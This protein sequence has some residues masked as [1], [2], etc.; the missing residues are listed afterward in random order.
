M[1]GGTPVLLWLKPA[2]FAKLVGEIDQSFART[3][4]GR[5]I[6]I[7]RGVFATG[8]FYASRERFYFPYVC[9]MWVA[10]KL[11]H[12]G[13]PFFLPRAILSNSL[14]LQAREKGVMLQRHSGRPEDY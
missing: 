10:V 14:I 8:R 5:R 6:Y 2:S 7:G 12:A 11:G 4:D 9:N 13:V 3:R 1:F